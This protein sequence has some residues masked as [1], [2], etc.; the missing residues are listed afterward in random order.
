MS[1][2]SEVLSVGLGVRT[3]SASSMPMSPETSSA[4]MGPRTG[5][6]LSGGQWEWLDLGACDRR[7][8]V[9]ERR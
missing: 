5:R 7:G 1:R 2:R 3:V 9:R 4:P 8:K 6:D